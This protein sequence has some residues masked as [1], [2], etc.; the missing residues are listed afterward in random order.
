MC[1][2][3]MQMQADTDGFLFTFK[4]IYPESVTGH[5]IETRDVIS[6]S[7]QSDGLHIYLLI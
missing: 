2:K 3:H 7:V 5:L 4:T 6:V 1:S